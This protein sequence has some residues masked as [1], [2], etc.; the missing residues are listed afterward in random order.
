MNNILSHLIS[1]Y[2][3]P[4]FGV[5]LDVH[6]KSTAASKYGEYKKYRL[7]TKLIKEL[8]LKYTPDELYNLQELNLFNQKL[9][10]LPESIGQLHNLKRLH[11][12]SNDNLNSL[13]ESIWQLQNLRI[14]FTNWGQLHI[15]NKNI[16]QNNR[17][18]I[19]EYN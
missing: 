7:L 14:I 16:Q 10:N 4:P 15:I 19:V 6:N 17:I 13:P 18:E 3:N 2:I 9:D 12:D 1:H 8:K 5:S 11:I